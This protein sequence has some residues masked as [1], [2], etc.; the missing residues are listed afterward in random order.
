MENCFLTITQKMAKIRAYIFD[1]DGVFNN[2]IKGL[3]KQST[4]SEIDAMG[5]NLLRFK[6]F[7][8]NNM[9]FISIITGANNL[10]AKSF[11]QR[12]NFDS[13]YT[14]IKNKQTALT[15]FMQQ[16]RL[17]KAEIAFFFDDVIDLSIAK[18]VGLR[19]CIRHKNANNYFNDYIKKNNC[20]DYITTS[21]GGENA[22]RETTELLLHLSQKYEQ[23]LTH[24]IG[25]T[26]LYQQYLEKKYTIQTQFF[27]SS[28][29]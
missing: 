24:R 15:H 3:H 18:Q 21:Y 7:V 16:Y 28:G 11:A 4:F 6:H 22:I 10:N 26:P 25:Y 19:I 14:N 29:F 5:I 12:E 23:I 20:V 1:W 9:P 8:C 17:K 27:T 13:V 2:G